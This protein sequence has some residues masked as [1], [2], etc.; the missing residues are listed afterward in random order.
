MCHFGFF[1]SVLHEEVYLSQLRTLLVL[2]HY[3]VACDTI[4]TVK[5]SSPSAFTGRQ[6]PA[7]GCSA[8]SH[9]NAGRHLIGVNSR[10]WR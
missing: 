2:Q 1:A 3:S 7:D 4:S 8:S 9:Y 5:V 6:Q 10:V